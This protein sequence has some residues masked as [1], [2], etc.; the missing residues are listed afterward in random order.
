MSRLAMG[1][2]IG[3]CWLVS[4]NNGPSDHPESITQRNGSGR[5]G[6]MLPVAHLLALAPLD[7]WIRMLIRQ[8]VHPK[9]WI[10]LLGIGFTSLVGTIWSLPER[11]GFW[12]GWSLFKKNPEQ[13]EHPAG[14]LVIVGYFRSGT[15]HA[16][17]LISCGSEIITPRWYQ[18]LLGQG[19]WMSW[20]VTRLLLVPFLGSSRPQDGVGFGPM[21]PAEDDFAL[22]SWG[23]CS[24]L[25]GRLIFPRSREEWDRWND[26]NEISEAERTRWRR[27]IAGFAWKVTRRD[28]SKM[29]VLKTPS[30]GAH[31]A[32]LKAVF[33]EHVRFLH[34]SRD[35]TSVIESNIRM[36]DALSAHL[37]EDP[38]ETTILRSQIVD[39]YLQ[40]ERM[41]IE[42][43]QSLGE[44]EMVFVSHEN[45]LAD[46]IGQLESAFETLGLEF[47]GSHKDAIIE[48]LNELGPYKRPTPASINLGSPSEHESKQIVQLLELRP[49]IEQVQGMVIQRRDPKRARLVTGV[50]CLIIAA[51]LWASF[52]IGVIWVIKLIDPE[53]KPRLDQ[54]VW[55]GGSVIGV[56]AIKASGRGSRRLGI[57]AALLTLVVF[58]GLSFP[59]TVLNWNFASDGTQEQFLYHNTKGALHGLLAPSSLIFAALGMITAFRHAGTT[60]PRPPGINH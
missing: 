44:G 30:H 29:L 33:G 47:S 17:N 20:A 13:F 12:I 5:S 18:A 1:Q 45:L 58:V 7:V 9:Y 15:T 24:T 51:V 3:I 27:T 21:W 50:L 54:L 38:I 42:Q 37:L 19:L 28:P 32:E 31:I 59:I 6:I 23:R 26:L 36:H 43:S 46:P 34:V 16:H 60:G 40:I 4:T 49:A 53:I 8:R 2:I 25:P 35:P 55:I 14:V 41:T 22:A 48:Y 57:V 11:V 56:A 52:W 39:E 10:R